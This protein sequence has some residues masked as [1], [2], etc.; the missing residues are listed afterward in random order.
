MVLTRSYKKKG[1]REGQKDAT[2]T[3][4]RNCRTGPPSSALRA[5]G[6]LLKKRCE[7]ETRRTRGNGG[8]R[9]GSIV[10]RET[11][12]E[13][14][15]IRSLLSGCSRGPGEGVKVL[16][17]GR[18]HTSYRKKRHYIMAAQ[19]IVFKA[20][21][22]YF[23]RKD[24]KIRNRSDPPGG[25]THGREVKIQK[26]EARIKDLV[27]EQE[28]DHVWT[29][30][31]GPEV[32]HSVYRAKPGGKVGGGGGG[33]IA[34]SAGG[35][36]RLFAPKDIPVKGREIRSPQRAHLRSTKGGRGVFIQIFEK[37]T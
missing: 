10:Q 4:C 29:K 19:T 5:G 14:G 16:A 11:R 12:V 35:F 2:G 28:I 3:D 13:V 18:D 23:A 24:Q 33:Q 31:S 7:V 6:K 34:P 17:G 1:R 9:W 32:R 27:K 8:G 22:H 30:K 25:K 15:M 20:V 36:F 37:V 21:S 26:E